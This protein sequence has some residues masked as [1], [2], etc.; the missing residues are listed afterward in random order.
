[1][2]KSIQLILVVVL[3]TGCSIKR[4]Y[5]H[6][7]FRY[8]GINDDSLY[9]LVERDKGTA[10]Y[11]WGPC[12]RDTHYS[13]HFRLYRLRYP[14]D[15]NNKNKKVMP[16]IE[17]VIDDSNGRPNSYNELTFFP[18]G[19]FLDDWYSRS[20]QWAYT[21]WEDQNILSSSK[22]LVSQQELELASQQGFPVIETRRI[23]R[24]E[25]TTI[26]Y[27][28]HKDG[29]THDPHRLYCV[30][31]KKQYVFPQG[32]NPSLSPMFSEDG[33]CLFVELH[34]HRKISILSWN[35]LTGDSDRWYLSKPSKWKLSKEKDLSNQQVDPIVKTPVDEVEAQGT[36]GHP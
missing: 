32:N 31:T 30:E 6:V 8:Y 12:P 25:E 13:K 15:K 7:W 3:I 2:I 24:N 33:E 21:D 27:A 36:Q 16:D 20:N 26:L 4:P 28:I 23:F 14:L 35:P 19:V 29:L 18:S 10:K 11:E 1:M 34:D 5:D 9:A 22:G 17:K